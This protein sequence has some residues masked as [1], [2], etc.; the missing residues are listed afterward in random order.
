MYLLDTN[1]CIQFLNGRSRL[2]EAQFRGHAP[3]QLKLC[4]VVKAEMIYG[5]AR[6]AHPDRN[7]ALMER[8]FAVYESFPFDDGAAASYGA[9]RQRL[10]AAG[11]PIGPNDLLIAAISQRSP[12]TRLSGQLI[13]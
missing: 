1:T 5:A 12:P 6:S 9:I 10:A 13:H 11:T 7:L 2:V 3:H 4:S 8:F